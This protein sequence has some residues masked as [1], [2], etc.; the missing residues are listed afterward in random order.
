MTPKPGG[1]VWA[2]RYDRPLEDIFAV[3]DEIVEAI[4]QRLMRSLDD[5]SIERVRRTPPANLTAYD[6]LLRARRNWVRSDFAA[7]LA[8]LKVAVALDPNLAPAYALMA[9]L[10]G[11]EHWILNPDYGNAEDR[12]LDSARRAHGPR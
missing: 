11:F 6:R 3:Q 8:N 4:V 2:E 9:F 5:E 1:H 12:A 7:A 10:H